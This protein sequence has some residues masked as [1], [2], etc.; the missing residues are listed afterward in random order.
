MNEQTYAKQPPSLMEWF[1]TQSRIVFPPHAGKPYDL[2]LKNISELMNEQVYPEVEKGAISK[3]GGFLTDHGPRHTET[4]IQRASSLLYHPEISY[5]QLTPYE[6]YLLLIA[7]YFHDVGNIFGRDR[8]EEKHSEVMEKI[9]EFI[10]N[11]MVERQAILKIA[12]AHGGRINGSKDTISTLLPVGPV[13]G[14]NV[15]YQTLAAILRFA[16]EL[17]DDCHR[18]SRIG[19]LLDV[20]PKGSEIFHAYARSLHSVLIHPHQNIVDLHYSFIKKDAIRTFGK[21][22]DEQT[23]KNVYLLDEIYNRT[24]KM[25]FERKYC[26]RFTQ[27]TVRIDAINVSIQVYEDKNSL[28]TCVDPIGYRLQEHGYP[29][30]SAI[31]ISDIWPEVKFDGCTLSHQLMRS[32]PQ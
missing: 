22:T 2:R 6:V 30:T 24:L 13:L 12:G 4:I 11:E 8:H 31:K 28:S 25:H 9:F 26:M 21:K 7:I 18:A 3:D 29:D 5:P 20:I 16:D 32:R 15:R 14:Q 1:S 23:I 17:A 19:Q 10:G 27:G